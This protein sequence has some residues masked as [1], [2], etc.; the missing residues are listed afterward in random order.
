[1]VTTAGSVGPAGSRTLY[2]IRSNCNVG[3]RVKDKLTYMLTILFHFRE[4]KDK[5][6]RFTTELQM[7]CSC[8][9]TNGRNVT[10][11]KSKF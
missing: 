4:N 1:M 2:A 7:L 10:Q 9:A 3:A 11:V 6:L 8:N 5:D